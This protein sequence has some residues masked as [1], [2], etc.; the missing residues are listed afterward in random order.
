MNKTFV[1]QEAMDPEEMAKEECASWVSEKLCEIKLL[2]ETWGADVED[3]H[4][5]ATA[6][7]CETSHV[8]LLSHS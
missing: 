1:L 6:G 3:A 5:T 7:W 8:V 2:I 4:A